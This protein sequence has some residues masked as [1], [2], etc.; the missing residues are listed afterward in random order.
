MLIYIGWIN[1]DLF[2]KPVSKIIIQESKFVVGA[3]LNSLKII[4]VSKPLKL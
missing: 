4:F 3:Y 2:Y 1:V